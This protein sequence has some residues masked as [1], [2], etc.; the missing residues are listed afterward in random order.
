MVLNTEQNKVSTDT[1]KYMSKLTWELKQL[2]NRNPDGG[3]GTRANRRKVLNMVCTQLKELG[4]NQMNKDALK[5]KHV[6]KLTDR[7][8]KE[9]LNPGTIKN[10]LSHVR[11]WASKVNAAHKI[12]SN[13]V[14]GVTRRV[15]VTQ[16]NKAVELKKE[17]LD[18][19]DNQYIKYSLRLQSAF[20]LRR[21]EAIKF[22]VNYADKG[23]HIKLKDTWCKG[24][25]TRIIPITNQKQRIL[26]EEIRKY[27]GGGSLIP[28][29]DRYIDQLNRYRYL[30]T[31]K[32]VGF[33]K[34]HGL[35]HDY[36]HRRYKELSGNEPPVRGGK[37]QADMKP[38]ERQK[39]RE[40]RLVLSE[41]MGHSREHI[42]SIYL[43]S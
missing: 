16:D 41:E 30:V 40:I 21:E 13:D 39:D 10:R 12:P 1:E 20:G 42:T 31:E 17:H 37:R 23:D 15:Y 35:R 36:A 25:R 4:F 11:W 34:G 6:R 32:N 43:G 19:L 2:Q 3:M 38:D 28:K 5:E 29:E 24:S 26:L 14:L 22:S 18:K 9:G 33:S 8:I 7:W 27:T